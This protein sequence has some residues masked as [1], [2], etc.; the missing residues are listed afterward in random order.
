MSLPAFVKP[1]WCANM[2]SMNHGIALQDTYPED[3]AHCFGCG[4]YNENGHQIMTYAT[5]ETTVTRHIPAPH[6]TGAGN[7]A[8]G[9]IIASLVDCHSA[10]SAAIFWLG[11]RGK[12]VGDVPAPRFVTARLEVDYLAPTPLGLV[13]LIGHAEEIGDRKAIVRTDMIAESATTAR[14]RT[15]LVKIPDQETLDP[16]VAG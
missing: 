3:F 9:G 5:G 13:E 4:R 11:R 1:A 6:Y 12:K 14:G 10:A 15:V 16:P 8:Y 7:F 2:T